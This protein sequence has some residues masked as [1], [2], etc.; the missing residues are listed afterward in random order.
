MAR[1]R[2]AVLPEDEVTLEVRRRIRPNDDGIPICPPGQRAER[3]LH[4]PEGHRIQLRKL[5]L[6]LDTTALG[7]DRAHR[8]DSGVLRTQALH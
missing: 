1:A 2:W 8:R 7:I 4:V 6:L 3:L 5:T